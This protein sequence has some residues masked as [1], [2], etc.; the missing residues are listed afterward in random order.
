V[1]EILADPNPYDTAEAFTRFY[2]DD[3]A[4]LELHEIDRERLRLRVGWAFCGLSTWGA[5]RLVVLDREAEKRRRR[6][7]R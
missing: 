2:H 5:Q 7:R 4:G 6:P 1:R 3:V